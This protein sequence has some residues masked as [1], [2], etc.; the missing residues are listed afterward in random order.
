MMP[1]RDLNPRRT[2]PAV[3]IGLIVINVLIFLYE[4]SLGSGL[5]GYITRSAFVPDEFF[6]PGNLAADA[7][8]ILVSMFLHGGLMHLLG[9]MLY[10]WIFGDNVED[11]MGHVVYLLFYL[12]AGAAASIAH[13]FSAPHSHVPAVG[14]S[15]AISGVLGAYLVMFPHARVLTLIPFGFYMRTSEMPAILV[16][17]LWFVLQFLSGVVGNSEGGGV[18]FWAHIGGFVFGMAIG[19]LYSRRSQRATAGFSGTGP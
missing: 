2:F 13:A 14:A 10:L 17:G 5:E 15:G 11:R 18:A 19:L 6:A 12:A 9:N 3:T 7:R 1:L 4:M 16:L 8:S